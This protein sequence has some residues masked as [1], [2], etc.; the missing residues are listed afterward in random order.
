MRPS[1]NRGFKLSRGPRSDNR[2]Y[3]RYACTGRSRMSGGDPPGQVN[4]LA[5]PRARP[6]LRLLTRTCRI[7][8][9]DSSLKVG[10]P[11][12]VD[13]AGFLVSVRL[14]QD[15]INLHHFSWRIVGAACTL[16]PR[17]LV[18]RPRTTPVLPRA[19]CPSSGIRPTWSIW[20]TPFPLLRLLCVRACPS[21]SM[22]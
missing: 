20:L 13:A 12:L 17:P 16:S 19:V 21:S 22:R 2:G 6:V 3:V 18:F 9:L 7:A 5:G 11:C 10:P 8:V 4:R 15:A 1:R 14:L